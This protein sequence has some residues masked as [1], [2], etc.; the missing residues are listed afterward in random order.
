[1]KQ[2]AKKFIENKTGQVVKA[3]NPPSDRFYIA[4]NPELWPKAIEGVITD[5]QLYWIRWIGV[6]VMLHMW[7][8]GCCHPIA[9]GRVGTEDASPLQTHSHPLLHCIIRF[10]HDPH[11][12]SHPTI[13]G[14]L[15]FR[16]L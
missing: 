1:M 16:H 9:I 5:D 13:Q 3:V 14:S 8:L 11:P 7:S 2:K 12:V 6:L 4:F 15:L 10:S